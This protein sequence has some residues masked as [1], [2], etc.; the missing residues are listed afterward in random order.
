MINTT[1]MAT[2]GD[3]RPV[4]ASYWHPE[5]A[6]APSAEELS[7]FCKGKLAGYKRPKTVA[8]IG[9]DDMPRTGTGKILHRKLRERFSD[10]D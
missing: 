4:I 7:D 2:D 3:G 10:K 5:G 8:F 9:K 6:S 1:S